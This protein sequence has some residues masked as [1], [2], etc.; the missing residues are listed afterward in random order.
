MD[1]TVNWFDM[2]IGVQ[3]SNVGSDGQNVEISSVR[4]LFARKPL[5]FWTL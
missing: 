2:P 4:P 3:I 1:T 5:S